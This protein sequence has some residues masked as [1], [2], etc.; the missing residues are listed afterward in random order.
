MSEAKQSDSG[1]VVLYTCT[2]SPPGRAVQ[3]VLKYLGVPYRIKTVDFDNG[4]HFSEDFLKV[5][6]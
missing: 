5:I 3:I 1:K 4:E 6:I 2:D